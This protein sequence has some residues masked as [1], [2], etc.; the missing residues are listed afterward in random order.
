LLSDVHTSIAV[1]AA[2]NQAPE[3]PIGNFATGSPPPLP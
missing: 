2:L 1:P 3:L